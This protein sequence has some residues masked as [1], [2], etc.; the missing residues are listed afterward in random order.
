MHVKCCDITYVTVPFKD[1]TS[2]NK[3][4]RFGHGTS[5]VCPPKIA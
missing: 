4:M 3:M 5:E 2:E 1:V